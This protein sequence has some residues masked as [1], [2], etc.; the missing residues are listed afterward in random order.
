MKIDKKISFADYYHDNQY[1]PKIPD[2]SIGKVVNKCGDN[3]YKPLANGDFKQLQSMHSN[4][5]NE[6][7]KTKTHDLGGK[8]VLIAKTF[9]YFGSNPLDLPAFLDNLK[10]GRAHK[11]RFPLDVV[12]AFTAF[13]KSQKVGVNAPPTSWPSNDD[14]WKTI[15]S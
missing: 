5:T 6:N 14:S 1:S 8:Y 4:G 3:I 13:I 7:P 2:F 12:S 15:E 9:C 10:V 11:C